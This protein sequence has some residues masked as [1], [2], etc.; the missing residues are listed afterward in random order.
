[1]ARRSLS[2]QKGIEMKFTFVRDT[3]AEEVLP[4]HRQIAVEAGDVIVPTDLTTPGNQTAE[5][6]EGIILARAHHMPMSVVADARD[7][8]AN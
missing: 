8:D 6:I 5:G 7:V 3:T 2:R 4:P 1:M